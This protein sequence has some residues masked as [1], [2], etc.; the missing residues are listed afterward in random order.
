[1]IS[2]RMAILSSLHD[3]GMLQG[4][5]RLESNNILMPE[6]PRSE[7][8]GTSQYQLCICEN[9]LLFMAVV[10]ADCRADRAICS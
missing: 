8:R 3:M 9:G 7:G 10:G 1:M 2:F 4:E 6:L 5:V